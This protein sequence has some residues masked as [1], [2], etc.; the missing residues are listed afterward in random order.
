MSPQMDWQAANSAFL[1]DALA[2]LRDRLSGADEKRPRAKPHDAPQWAAKK[3]DAPNAPALH[4][5]AYRFA[6][7]VFE[8][9]VLLFCAAVELDPA[10]AQLCSRAQPDAQTQQPSFAVCLSLFDQ[11]SW[12][13]LSPERPLR[14]WRLI[15]LAPSIRL[16]LTA[17]PLRADDR[18]VNFIKGLNHLDERVS[19]FLVP[20][21]ADG[22][23]ENVL[24][25]SQRA[26]ADELSTAWRGRDRP[27]IM[28]SG[29]DPD[30]K[31]L[32]A[33]HAAHSHGLHLCRLPADLLPQH[34]GDIDTFERLWRRESIL[35]P[36]ALY[37]DAEEQDMAETSSP[38]LRRLL[39]RLSGAV[40]IGTREAWPSARQTRILPVA[41]P[42]RPE[43]EVLWRA[44]LGND[45]EAVARDLA[46]HFSLPGP[47]ITLLAG[48]TALPR[49]EHTLAARDGAL[50]QACRDMLRP[51]LDKL[52][53]RVEARATWEDIV[54]PDEQMQILQQI[55]GQVRHRARIYD[56]WGFAGRSSR[57]LGISVLFAGESGTGKTLAAEVI[58][59]ALGLDLYRID[60]SGV[61]SKYIGETEKNLR[62]LFEAA[63]DGGAILFFD[64][65]DA[66]FGKRSEVKDSHDRYANIEINYLL[67]RIEAYQGLAILATNLRSA[68]D[69]A[70]L[71]RLRFVVSFPY[72][73]RAERRQIW[74]RAFPA[75]AETGSLDHDRL[76]RLNLTGGN[77]ATVAL[78]AAFLAAGEDSRV[79][80]RH[81][82]A[83]CRN[84]Y[85]KLDRP[86]NEADF[87]LPADPVGQQAA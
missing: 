1:S 67:Q 70:F 68:L 75:A 40:A 21:G 80:M 41:K 63:E 56:D 57:G 3:P 61:V 71:R 11:P 12:D 58:A 13:A 42:N 55:V 27:V 69:S 47:A 65:A 73:A 30:S 86:M 72:P 44:A 66:L 16:P 54:L 35:M 32:V 5:L 52:A 9:Q 17:T 84:E 15:E 18:I 50:W 2:W 14:F 46:S 10:I 36:L 49:G 60:L 23:T 28:L 33:R 38:M 24:P 81:V 76:A 34:M 62:R 85:V 83:A 82:L 26:V 74:L 45:S 64:E 8:T 31:L 4:Q 43:Q 59:N 79:E 25:P 77:I 53:Q 78:N 48:T 22:L 7:S 29:P 37:I 51:R 19:A 6:L 87:R 39:T 20:A